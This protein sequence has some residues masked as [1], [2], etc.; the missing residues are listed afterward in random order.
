MRF[1]CRFP[2]LASL[3]L[4]AATSLSGQSADAPAAPAPAPAAQPA[5]APSSAAGT[6]SL[7]RAVA[8]ALEKNFDLRISRSVRSTANDSLEVAKA[9]FDPTFSIGANRTYSNGR[10][11]FSPGAT[12]SLNQTS[13]QVSVSQQV[14][15]G[16]TVTAGGALDRTRQRPVT[17]AWDP[18]FD[19]DVSLSVRQPL[20]KGAGPATVRAGV[21]RARVGVAKAVADLTSSVLG[22]V[23]TVENAFFA[24][25]YTRE[26]RQVRAFSL[27]VAQK[28]LDEARTRR[29][30]GVAT[31]I[32]V[33]Q[34]EV[35]VAN[36]KR[37]LLSAEQQ[38]KNSEDS[39]VSLISPLDFGSIPDA[40]S[41]PP[42]DE[43][44]LDFQAVLSRARAQSPDVT[45]ATLAAQQFRIDERVARRNRLPE[46]D[47]Q[48]GV[49]YNAR[50]RSAVGA[51]DSV[52]GSDLYNWQLGATLTIPWGQR[53]DKARLRTAQSNALTAELRA[54]QVDQGLAVN[55][56]AAVRAVETAREAVRITGL[57]TEL[58]QR[59]YELEKA[60]YD[61]GVSTFRRVQES[62]ED[63]DTARIN[64][65]QTK[66]D[67]RNALAE[68]A[69]LDG[70]SLEKYRIKID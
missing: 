62:R 29:E 44:P 68:L 47:V 33:L 53:A 42:A 70:S 19:S 20:L 36:A 51:V 65:L 66:I 27:E 30:T 58:S 67:L 21:E 7:E 3:G 57:A 61:A 60:R 52:W 16:G 1:L 15:T 6:L 18:Y 12:A 56:R 13:A 28:L 31:D 4:A 45:S 25:T 34:A 59:Q 2:V 63:L 32:D 35:L 14:A 69:R 49:G 26:Q 41:L 50:D 40:L 5:S 24:V 39:L 8:M 64:E 46:L 9:Q 23:R 10:S 17:S 22:T 48:A 11:Q 38:V 55:V 54:Q 43:R 37:A